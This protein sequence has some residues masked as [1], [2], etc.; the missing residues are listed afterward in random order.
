MRPSKPGNRARRWIGLALLVAAA[1]TPAL[2]LAHGSYEAAARRPSFDGASLK[3]MGVGGYATSRRHAAIRV[4]V[5]LNKRYGGQFFTV[6]CQ[7]DYDS[8]KRV[9]AR[10]SVPG[11]V[12]GV[13]RTT[14]D[15]AAL[16]RGGNWGH[17]ASDTSRPFHC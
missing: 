7:T 3:L 15:G 10:V 14:A 2:A 1:L 5:C 12:K 17:E 13:W 16:G 6:Q 8:G 9:K 11:C 4:T